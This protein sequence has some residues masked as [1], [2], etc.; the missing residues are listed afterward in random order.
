M[1]LIKTISNSTFTKSSVIVLNAANE[2]SVENFLKKNIG[3][4][5]IVKTI[6]KTIFKFNHTDIKTLKDVLS[7][8]SE[9]RS[10]TNQII[11]KKIICN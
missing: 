5:D 7:V 1:S 10:L 6:K 11:K 3:F 2:V 9:A 4:N 8:D